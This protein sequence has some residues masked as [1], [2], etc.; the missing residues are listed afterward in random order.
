MGRGITFA[1]ASRENRREVGRGISQAC[2]GSTYAQAL[3]CLCLLLVGPS[4]SPGQLIGRLNYLIR[5]TRIISLTR[6]TGWDQI[7]VV[8]RILLTRTS[9]SGNRYFEG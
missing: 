8:S 1:Y 2:I 6:G 7:R 9:V 4:R 3:R 5:L